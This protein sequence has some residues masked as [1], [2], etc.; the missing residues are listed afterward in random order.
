MGWCWARSA[1]PHQ[2]QGG[3]PLGG[4]KSP[5]ADWSSNCNRMAQKTSSCSFTWH[6]LTYCCVHAHQ[7]NSTQLHLFKAEGRFT[8]PPSAGVSGYFSWNGKKCFLEKHPWSTPLSAPGNNSPTVF[9]SCSGREEKEAPPRPCERPHPVAEVRWSGMAA[10]NDVARRE[11]RTRGWQGS[12]IKACSDGAK[13][14]ASS[15]GAR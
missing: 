4:F 5:S 7:H 2:Y 3:S 1:Q 10:L 13:A 12:D 14:S 6:I 15:E 11:G 8:P 9:F